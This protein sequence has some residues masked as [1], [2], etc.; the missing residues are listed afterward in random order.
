[1]CYSGDRNVLLSD[2]YF[3]KS[4]LYLRPYFAANPWRTIETT[5]LKRIVLYSFCVT[6]LLWCLLGVA[7][8]TTQNLVSQFTAVPSIFS[9]DGDKK[10][11]TAKIRVGVTVDSVVVTLIVLEDDSV[12]VV[13]TVAAGVYQSSGGIVEYVWD[14]TDSGGLV[15][16][17]GKYLVRLHAQ[18]AAQEETRYLPVWVDNTAPELVIQQIVPAVYTPEVSSQ[19]PYVQVVFDIFNSTPQGGLPAG[20]ILSGTVSEP[21]PNGAV[22]PDSVRFVPR[23]AGDG[24]YT[25]RWQSA[26]PTASNPEGTYSITLVI[27]DN[28]GHSSSSTANVEVN[29]NPPTI[30]ITSPSN[31]RRYHTIPDSLHGTIYDKYGI[32]L[33]SLGVRYSINSPELP[34]YSLYYGDNDNLHF[35][36]PLADSIV[37]ERKYTLYIDASDL[38]EFKKS[39]EFD[40]T[41]DRTAPPAPVLDPL[42]ATTN[43]SGIDLTGTFSGGPL[44]IFVY[45]NGTAIDTVVAVNIK[46]LDLRVPL[47]KGSNTFTATAVDEAGN[48]GPPSNAVSVTFL[49]QTGLYIPAP[50]LPDDEFRV[51]LDR[52][53]Y[54]LTVRIYDLGG[55]LVV[56][57]PDLSPG[58]NYMLRWDGKNGG[59][60]QVKKGPLVAV[61]EV[62]F[63]DGEKTV[64]REI[65]LFDP[66][67]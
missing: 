50:F 39:Q 19:P 11:D 45:R 59:G 14:G 12:A 16:S 9:P 23:F 49:D 1:M 67:Y 10:F 47:V 57:L 2:A 62:V 28:V 58:R 8:T 3:S 36:I 6:G 20:D 34:L 29:L 52:D 40:I 18:K 42:P 30:T 44:L 13:K 7:P 15:V 4:P 54:R 33:T 38:Y 61:A 24:R 26:N 21:E 51:N 43:A 31:S 55:E 65:F 25:A 32:D 56:S 41:L 53:A 5:G 37:E 46:K 35:S 63:A 66:R 17:D 27:T 60:E 48:E 22:L 64:Y